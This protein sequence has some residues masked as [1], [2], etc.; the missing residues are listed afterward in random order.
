MRT[1]LIDPN[2]HTYVPPSININYLYIFINY[3]IPIIVFIVCLFIMKIKN[4]KK[5]L[6]IS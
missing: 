6:Y 3:I 5:N 1:S 4:N 2:I